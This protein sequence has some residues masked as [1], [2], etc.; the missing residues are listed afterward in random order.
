MGP[1]AYLHLM[2]CC[3]PHLKHSGDGRVINLGSAVGVLGMLE[4]DPYG[5]AKEAVRSLTRTAAR[6][7]GKDGITVNNLLPI[8]DTS[9]SDRPPLPNVADRNGLPAEDIAPVALFLA[10]PDSR[11]IT[12]T[13]ISADGVMTIDAAR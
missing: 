6:E 7:W 3:H 13:S 8:A 12:G 11:F 4:Y 1:F 5:M 10:S 2:Q 9:G